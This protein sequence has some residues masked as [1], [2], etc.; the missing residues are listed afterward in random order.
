MSAA[1]P[2]PEPEALL[3]PAY[4]SW[5]ASRRALTATLEAGAASDLSASQLEVTL[6]NAL[7][8]LLLE[9]GARPP[10]RLHARLEP[11]HLH[12]GLSCVG[13]SPEQ[14]LGLAPA[15]C[16][17]IVS[18]ARREPEE[19]APDELAP[20]LSERELVVGE[21]RLTRDAPVERLLG[22]ATERLGEQPGARAVAAAALRY[23]SIHARTRHIGPPQRVYDHL[24][25]WGV[26]NEGFASPF[27]ARLLGRPEGRFFSAFA[28]TD[29][30]FGSQ[31]SFFGVKDPSEHPGAWCLDPPFLPETMRRTEAV[32]RRWR[33]REAPPTILLIVPSS[34]DLALEPDEHVELTHE[35]HHYEGL[36]GQLHPL[37]VDVSIY[38]FGR[39]EG[40][41]AR[42]I[43]AGYL[44]PRADDDGEGA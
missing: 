8:R 21:F 6:E 5:R 17:A 3:A 24:W 15:L 25:R 12:R 11:R 42:T 18:A 10:M 7:M 28:D 29:G 39:L 33:D 34:H 26:R 20:A 40:F 37:P 1:P 44:P 30:P 4:E 32:I 31:G 43:Q 16:D 22:V 27:N 14:R 38:R 13:A 41:D 9:F 23:A 2:S 35:R 36:D 19:A